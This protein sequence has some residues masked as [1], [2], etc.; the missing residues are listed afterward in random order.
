ME[1]GVSTSEFL[2]LLMMMEVLVEYDF[3]VT[4][5]WSQIEYFFGSNLTTGMS[6]SIA[7]S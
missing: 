4:T 1:E 7:I 6:I 3:I 2:I 5:G